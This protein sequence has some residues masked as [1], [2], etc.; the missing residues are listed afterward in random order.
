V[1]AVSVGSGFWSPRDSSYFLFLLLPLLITFSCGKKFDPDSETGRR[2][3]IDEVNRLLSV[4]DCRAAI[5]LIEP[6]YNSNN[7]TN[8]IR[9]LRA[10]SHACNAKI[11]FFTML[12]NLTSASFCSGGNCNSFWRNMSKFFYTQGLDM[13]GA[14]DA[15]RTRMYSSWFA[16]DSLQA[17]TK[18]GV[19][20]PEEM[21]STPG[22]VNSGSL[23]A[24]D[25]I[26]DANFYM[27]F[28]SMSLLGNTQNLYAQRSDAPFDSTYGRRVALPWLTLEAMTT[29][30]CAYASSFLNL[31][32]AIDA[33]GSLISV[34]LDTGLIAGI[35]AGCAA[36]CTAAVAAGGCAKTAAECGTVCSTRLR[37]RRACGE[38]SVSKCHAVGL[39]N[40]INAGG[41]Y[42]YP[43]VDAGCTP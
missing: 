11:N 15:I 38:D 7:T 34:G 24:T 13:S 26:E 10:S 2:G 8:E 42:G 1:K 22:S 20:V 27:I 40:F 29:E 9:M 3:I 18:P 21:Q 14:D 12:S 5:E 36:T 19:V 25:R 35:N 43:C 37:H 28:V 4:E 39:V 31:L 33:S 41:S 17:M 23:I 30:G 32:D 6:L 16:L